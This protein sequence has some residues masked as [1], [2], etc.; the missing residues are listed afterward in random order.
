MNNP[1]RSIVDVRKIIKLCHHVEVQVR[2]GT[3]ERWSKLSKIEA[4][5][6]VSSIPDHATP[7]DCGMFTDTFGDFDKTSG[8]FYLG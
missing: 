5:E 1:I 6:L 7:E 3:N 4:L 2:F 8:I